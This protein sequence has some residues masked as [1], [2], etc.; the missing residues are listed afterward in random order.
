MIKINMDKAREIKKNI[1]RE[2]RKPL[3]EKLD[4]EF[5]KAFEAGDAEK[6]EEIK[7]K[8]QALRDATT[9]PLIL[10]A[11]DPQELKEVRPAILNQV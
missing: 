10:S 5:M 1:I 2:E 9:D 11:S 7:K 8:K 6:I 4:I 3:L